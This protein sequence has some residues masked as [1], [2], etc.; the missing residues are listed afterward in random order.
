[1]S[2]LDASGSASVRA[3]S[4][5]DGHKAANSNSQHSSD[6]LDAVHDAA[7]NGTGTAKAGGAADQSAPHP[8]AHASVSHIVQP[9]ETLGALLV[10]TADILRPNPAVRDPDPIGAGQTLTVQ[11]AKADG[12]LPGLHVVQPGDTLG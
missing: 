4:S 2:R 7:Q 6:W 9:G 12:R 3:S 1:M 11:L 10:P 8:H 5:R